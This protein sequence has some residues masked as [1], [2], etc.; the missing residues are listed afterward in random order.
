MPTIQYAGPTGFCDTWFLNLN[1]NSWTKGP[2]MSTCR[3]HHS[4]ALLEDTN[5][6]VI[7]GGNTRRV[8]NTCRQVYQNSVEILDLNTNTIRDGKLCI[9]L[10]GLISVLLTMIHESR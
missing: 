3:S 9:L 8:N 5:E 7:I 6:I 4:C 2:D 1:D 10:K